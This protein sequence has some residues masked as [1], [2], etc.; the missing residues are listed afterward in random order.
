MGN[1]G[2]KITDT[3]YKGT[4]RKFVLVLMK[5]PGQIHHFPLVTVIGKMVSNW[6]I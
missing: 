3:N 6:C 4:T 2:V 1:Q 5:Q